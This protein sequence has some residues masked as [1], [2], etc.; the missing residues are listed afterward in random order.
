MEKMFLWHGIN[1]IEV[2]PTNTTCTLANLSPQNVSA[3]SS[4][5]LYHLRSSRSEYLNPL[6]LCGCH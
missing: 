6:C 4:L 2:L 3:D 1:Q 5:G